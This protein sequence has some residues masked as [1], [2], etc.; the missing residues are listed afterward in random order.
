MNAVKATLEM[1]VG[2]EVT[3]LMLVSFITH[4]GDKIKLRSA[5]QGIIKHARNLVALWRSADEA[6]AD[7]LELLAPVL[8]LK[9][10]AALKLK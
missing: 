3:G 7:P 2:T 5:L 8:S 1:S 10:K 6:R 4:K 9:V